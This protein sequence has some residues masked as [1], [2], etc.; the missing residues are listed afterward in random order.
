MTSQELVERIERDMEEARKMGA[1]STP[2][3]FVNGERLRNYRFGTFQT[4][5]EATLAADSEPD[6]SSR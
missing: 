1:S 4:A 5:I 6:E 3:F 2:T